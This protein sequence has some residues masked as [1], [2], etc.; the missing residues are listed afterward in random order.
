MDK[1][2]IYNQEGQVTG[3]QSLNPAIFSIKIKPEVV[4]Q[5]VVALQA[6]SR[7]VLAATKDR[8]QVRGGGIK[9]W[10]Q[11]GTGRARHGSIR[12]PLW[13]GGGITFGPTTEVNFNLKINKKTRRKAL[14]MGLTDKAASQKIILVDE[15]NLPEIKTKKFF[16][17]L[18]NLDLREKKLKKSPKTKV[19]KDKKAK[20]EKIQKTKE[21][22]ILLVLSGKDEKITKSARN[23]DRLKVLSANSL[24]VLDV[25]RCQYIL[26]PVK[27]LKV[28]EE[29]FLKK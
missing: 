7:Q 17:V 20:E 2:K 13:R 5:V 22:R 28:I 6:N 15:L 21:K 16:N 27:A 18:Q 29:T 24:N 14:F 3:E 23:I 25:L 26:M 4:Q 10:R 19:T 8:S 9:P 11:K 1:I 12:S